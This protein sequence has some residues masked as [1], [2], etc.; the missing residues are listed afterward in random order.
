MN[1]EKRLP[2]SSRIMESLPKRKA[3]RIVRFQP[4]FQWRAMRICIKSPLKQ[5]SSL[6]NGPISKHK[7][8]MWHRAEKHM[9]A[10][11]WSVSKRLL[12]YSVKTSKILAKNHVEDRRTPAVCTVKK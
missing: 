7:S 11:Q 5:A 1:R 10:C 3:R 4:T 2:A 6:D 9:Q 12:Q 8:C